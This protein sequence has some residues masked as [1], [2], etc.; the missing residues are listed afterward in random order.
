MS[1][2]PSLGGGCATIGIKAT[3]DMRFAQVVSFDAKGEVSVICIPL[4]QI[5]FHADSTGYVFLEGGFK[6]E[7]GPVFLNAKI[8][9]SVLL[10]DWQIE[11]AGSGGLNIPILSGIGLDLQGVVG[12]RGLAACASLKIIFVRVAAGAGVRF[13]NGR[14]PLT[15]PELISNLRLFTGCDLSS[16]KSLPA[17]VRAAQAGGGQSFDVEAGGRGVALSFQGAGG[18][19]RVSLRSPSGKVY[20]FSRAEQAMTIDNAFGV[21]VPTEDRT[22]V[23]L[24][25]PEAG[26]WTATVAEGSTPIARIEKADILPPARV[27]GKVGGIGSSRVLR[28]SVPRIAGQVV[29]IVE[30]ANG[31]Q[32]EL[33]TVRGGGRGT[34][35]F[36]T[37]EAN[38]VRRRIVAQVTQDGMPRDNIT[39]AS[40]SAP[41]PRVG[42]ARRV[43]VKRRGRTAVVTWRPAQLAR[44]Y[45]VLA[46]SGDGQRVLLSP[47]GRRLRVTVRGRH[48][49]RGRRRPDR[50]HQPRRAPRPRGPRPPLGLAAPRREEATQ[51]AAEYPGRDSNPHAREGRG[52]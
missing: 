18:A 46:T 25:K 4:V 5:A 14:P 12:N 37:S 24:E 30:E 50:R 1:V 40:F 38:G 51:G 22:V 29:R 32:K 17:R 9:G 11:I 43:R 13:I 41:S 35:R 21:I 28:Y 45:D 20:D 49:G 10:P 15:L 31:A 7:A 19:P 23:L 8:A 33:R 52:F 6:F 3:F 16:W 39:V 34:V 47:T 42:R 48:E 44:R 27:T 26:R 2:G 36:T